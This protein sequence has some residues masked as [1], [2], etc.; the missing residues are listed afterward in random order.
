M[1]QVTICQGCDSYFELMGDIDDYTH[2]DPAAP[3]GTRKIRLCPTCWPGVQ[4]RSR[5]ADNPGDQ[6]GEHAEEP[7][8]ERD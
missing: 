2:S 8:T 6:G 3:L 1:A 5:P 7:P 4:A